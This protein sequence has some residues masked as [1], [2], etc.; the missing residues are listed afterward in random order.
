M[1]YCVQDGRIQLFTSDLSIS[2]SI[3]EK[4]SD[5]CAPFGLHVTVVALL[6]ILVYVK[7]AEGLIHL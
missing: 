7:G 4:R 3:P 5:M 1:D 6:S 2:F